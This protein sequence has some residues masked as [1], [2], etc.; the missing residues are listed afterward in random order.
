MEAYQLQALLIFG[1]VILVIKLGY[2]LRCIWRRVARKKPSSH[3]YP[4]SDHMF[5][6]VSYK[7]LFNATD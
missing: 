6:K 3:V 7:E 4:L 2:F 1:A 5:Q